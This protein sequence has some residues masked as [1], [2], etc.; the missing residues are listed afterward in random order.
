[1]ENETSRVFELKLYAE[2]FEGGQFVL[3]K[4][5][6]EISSMP[7]IPCSFHGNINDVNHSG[8]Q[9]SEYFLFCQESDTA[10][11]KARSK[12]LPRISDS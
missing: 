2:K 6:S 3:S 11:Q 5:E 10:R 12:I 9:N 4:T 1:M 7:Q 8:D